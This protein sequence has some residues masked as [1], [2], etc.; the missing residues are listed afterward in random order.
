VPVCLLPLTQAPPS[1]PAP[2]A[3]TTGA[4]KQ[5]DKKRG[6]GNVRS[7]SDM[8][9]DSDDEDEKPIETF[10]GGAKRCVRQAHPLSRGCR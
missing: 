7:L 9:D 10:I 1:G 8:R 6:A 5:V 3:T 4:K 2:S